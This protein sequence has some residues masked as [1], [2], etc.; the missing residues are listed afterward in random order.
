ME[1]SPLL[2]REV[3]EKNVPYT[4]LRN[5]WRSVYSARSSKKAAQEADVFWKKKKKTPKTKKI[6][7][8]KKKKQTKNEMKMKF[9]IW[10]QKNECINKRTFGV[11]F[12]FYCQFFIAF[13]NSILFV[14]FDAIQLMKCLDNGWNALSWQALEREQPWNQGKCD[15][16]RFQEQKAMACPLNLRTDKPI[17]AI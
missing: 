17:V 15:T 16:V 6:E 8:K 9:I 5:H 2:S 1:N 3:L 12:F 7:W 4:L 13:V 11:A 10:L 14:C